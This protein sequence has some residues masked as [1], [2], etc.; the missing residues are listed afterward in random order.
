[1][2]ETTLRAWYLPP[3]RAAVD[4]GALSIM[5]SFSSWNGVK[6]HAQRY[7][8]TDVLKGE[9]G[10]SGFLIS[11]WGAV[12]QIAP[13]YHAA[14]VAALNAGIDMVMTPFDYKRFITET[15]LAVQRGEIPQ[16]RI[17][18]AVRRI[19]RA[20]F[21][22]G[23]FEHP[24][25]DPALAAQVG[26]PEH[27]ALAREAVRASLVLLLNRERTLPLDQQAP[28]IFVGGEA[29]DDV[30]RQVGGWGLD[31]QGRTGNITPGTSIVDAL[32]E[33]VGPNTRVVFNRFGK[34]DNV[35]DA[36][37]AP[38]IA[39]VGVVV[40]AEEPYAEGVGDRADLTLPEA[41][42]ALVARVKAR[43]RRVVVVL[44]SGRPLVVTPYLADWDA[45]VAAWW[46]GTEGAGVTDVLFGDEPFTGRLP[47][48]WPRWNAQLPFDL[49]H[50]PAGGCAAPLFPYG[51][52]LD[53]GDPSP[54]LPDCPAP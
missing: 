6:L 23:L 1:V 8:L 54:T 31:W 41:S 15:Q 51:Y 26:S 32:R 43:S 20:K 37:G 53:T 49:A 25:S 29:A 50:L 11:D 27:R 39:D 40:L 36:Q 24:Y 33:T 47:Y 10:F 21:T 44:L 42:A 46:P 16:A 38:L 22:L 5:V 28:L 13:D 2:D 3:Y 45:L 14:V 18:D 30:G 35:V 9:L 4:A 12:D 7:L 48:S 17:D 52:G 34:Y 19:L